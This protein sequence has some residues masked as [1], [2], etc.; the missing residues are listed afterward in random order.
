[1]ADGFV[2]ALAIEL[3]AEVIEAP[4]LLHQKWRRVELRF[5]P[6]GSCASAHATHFAPNLVTDDGACEDRATIVERAH[7]EVI[8]SQ[9]A[10]RGLLARGV[11]EVAHPFHL[12]E[13]IAQLEALHQIGKC[14]EVVARLTHRCDRL[15]HRDDETIARGRAEIGIVRER[16][17][18]DEASTLNA[19]IEGA[20]NWELPGGVMR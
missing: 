7:H 6:A 11:V 12:G 2:R 13:Q 17:A 19:G 3:V 16:L 15:L 8:P 4:L 20:T 9:V 1:L 5:R 18:I 14:I 10:L